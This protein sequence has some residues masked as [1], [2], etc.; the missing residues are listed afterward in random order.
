[1]IRPGR[2]IASNSRGYEQ[3]SNHDG[4]PLTGDP[5]RAYSL[6][7]MTPAKPTTSRA[8][9]RRGGADFPPR[10]HRARGH[11]LCVAGPAFAR[12]RVQ[13]CA[14]GGEAD[15]EYLQGHRSAAAEGRGAGGRDREPDVPRG[16]ACGPA[17]TGGAR[18]PAPAP[19]SAERAQPDRH[20]EGRA[21]RRRLRAHVERPGLRPVPQDVVEGEGGRAARSLSA[22]ARGPQVRDPGLRQTG[23]ERGGAGLRERRDSRR[24]DRDARPGGHRAARNGTATGSTASSTGPSC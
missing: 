2:R 22:P 3:L 24:G 14:R 12:H 7:P 20:P 8:V 17:G 19:G 10:L 1:M 18:L 13:G 11:D 5:A 9:A 15:R 4:E 16:A 21:G 23:R 6:S